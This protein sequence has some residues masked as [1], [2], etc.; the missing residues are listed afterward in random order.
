MR[1]AAK[2]AA[3]PSI[4]VSRVI[5]SLLFMSLTTRPSASLTLLLLMPP[6]KTFRASESMMPCTV[7]VKT[8]VRCARA[9]DFPVS[10]KQG[11]SDETGP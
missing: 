10:R 4:A 11:F 6:P 3:S 7:V 9:C 2:S 1:P 8:L 5:G